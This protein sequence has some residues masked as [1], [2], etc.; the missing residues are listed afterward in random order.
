MT[1]SHFSSK[2]YHWTNSILSRR[3]SLAAS[4]IAELSQQLHRTRT[5]LDLQRIHSARDRVLYY[6]HLNAQ[7]QPRILAL[8]RPLK[9]IAAELNLSPEAF[10]RTLSQLQQEGVITRT[11]RTIILNE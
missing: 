8:D 7:L 10:S 6:P 4:Y 3:C 1:I 2:S 9:E 11:K 5:L